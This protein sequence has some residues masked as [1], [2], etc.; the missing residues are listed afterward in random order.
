L[1][2]NA[3][4]A[5]SDGV[6]EHPASAFGGRWTEGSLNAARGGPAALRRIV[7]RGRAA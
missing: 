2:T 7:S 3:A 5:D 1:L 6:A 4:A